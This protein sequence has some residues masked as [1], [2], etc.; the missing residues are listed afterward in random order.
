MSDNGRSW[1]GSTIATQGAVSG[2]AT[3]Y[4]VYRDY[5]Y[6]TG[7]SPRSAAICNSIQDSCLPSPTNEPASMVTSVCCD[8]HDI[9]PAEGLLGFGGQKR[10]H[11][12]CG[13]NKVSRQAKYVLVAVERE[14]LEE[15]PNL[16]SHAHSRPY[17]P[18]LT[19]TITCQRALIIGYEGATHGRVCLEGWGYESKDHPLGDCGRTAK[20][21]RDRRSPDSKI[22]PLTTESKR[23]LYLQWRVCVCVCVHARGCMSC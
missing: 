20:G 16:S 9:T 18:Q 23:L 5:H 7:K 2:H 11:L 6:S 14:G 3:Q 21:N 17:F 15:A 4:K 13:N 19:R 22:P 1:I 12:N 8:M 10:G